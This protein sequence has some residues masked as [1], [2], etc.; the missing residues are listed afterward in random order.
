MPRDFVISCG[1]FSVECT[2]SGLPGHYDALKARA[3]LVDEAGLDER[4]LCCLLVRRGQEPWPSLVLALG[5][6]AAV[7][8]T[9]PG[10]LLTDA[11]TLFVGYGE[12]ALGYALR[13][14]AR[15]WAAQAPGGFL[16]WEQQGAVV[17]LGAAG[18]L[19]AWSQQG[20]PLW[21][22]AL[23]QPWSHRVQAG[24]VELTDGAGRSRRFP[25]RDG[26]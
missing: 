15:L 19:S 4:D 26:P 25:L 20:A 22:V 9:S 7:A 10:A 2:P 21:R 6:P 23:A 5:C 1:D 8:G 11:G 16:F 14:P 17:L 3:A 12:R 24:Q 13:E 18:A